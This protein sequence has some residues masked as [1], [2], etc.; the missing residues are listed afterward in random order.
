MNIKL[1]M[2]FIVMDTLT[3]LAYSFIFMYSKV[4]K[5]PKPTGRI[6]PANLS[7]PGAKSPGG[8]PIGS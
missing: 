8:T 2:L 5:V 3:M 1:I 4:R 6:A 7:I